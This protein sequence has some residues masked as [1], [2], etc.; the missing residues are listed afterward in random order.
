MP[1]KSDSRPVRSPPRL[2]RAYYEC[3][4]GQL[5]VHN[6]IPAGGGFDEKT[7]L[8][9]IHGSGAT[10]RAFQELLAA[11]GADRSIYAPDLPGAGESDPAPGL[12]MAEAALAA[13]QDF[14]DTMRLREVDVLGVQ[15]GAL[16]ARQ[17]ASVR[18]KAVRRVVL[19]GDV[20]P[21]PAH[22]SL[23]LPAQAMAQCIAR[24]SEF[25]D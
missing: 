20:G 1:V 6:A 12:A 18:G 15:E 16:L 23:Q 24:I 7:A 5:H 2:R 13:L 8:L 17:L 14:L 9:C 21:R 10:G 19:I 25:L 11:L 3:R 22:P 4:F